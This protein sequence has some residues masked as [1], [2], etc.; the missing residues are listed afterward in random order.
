MENRFIYT[1]LERLQMLG[2]IK[3]SCFSLLF[4]SY[5]LLCIIQLC[6]IMLKEIWYGTTDHKENLWQEEWI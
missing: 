6:C 4:I 2:E 5:N 1:I 3:V